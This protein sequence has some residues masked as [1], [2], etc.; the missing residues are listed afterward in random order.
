MVSAQP[1]NTHPSPQ[2]MQK[3]RTDFHNLPRR[4]KILGVKNVTLYCKID[5]VIQLF[6]WLNKWSLTH[7]L[8]NT[9]DPLFLCPI[10]PGISTPEKLAFVLRLEVAGIG[11]ALFHQSFC[12]KHISLFCAPTGAFFR[13][14][15]P[16]PRYTKDFTCGSGVSLNPC[17][18]A[19][20]KNFEKKS[21]FNIW[22]QKCITKISNICQDQ[23]VQKW[24]G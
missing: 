4:G 11:T 1:P 19:T 24:P 17:I 6:Q 18:S 5:T 2:L 10:E 9:L 16:L 21:G 12:F 22:S 23:K 13:W 20:N 8:Y 15:P 3:E 7:R 14:Y